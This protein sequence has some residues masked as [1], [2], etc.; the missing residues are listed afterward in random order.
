MSKLTP[1]GSHIVMRKINAQNEHDFQIKE[2]DFMSYLST[3]WKYPAKDDE[4]F[5]TRG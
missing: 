4:L 5:L 2:N 3:N 1:K